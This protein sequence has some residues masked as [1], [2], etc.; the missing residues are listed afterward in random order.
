MRTELI[1]PCI[2][3]EC[4]ADLQQSILP[5]ASAHASVGITATEPHVSFSTT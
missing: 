5:T 4:V 2:A 3:S 1:I